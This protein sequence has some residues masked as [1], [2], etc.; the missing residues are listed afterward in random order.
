MIVIKYFIVADVSKIEVNRSH[1]VKRSVS[2]YEVFYIATARIKR[3]P[4]VLLQIDLRPI[5]F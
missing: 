5:V 1:S 3:D 4:A 2:E